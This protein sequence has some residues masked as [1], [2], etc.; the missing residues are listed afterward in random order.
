MTGR[1]HNSRLAV[2]LS[3]FF[4]KCFPPPQ[5]QCLMN[6]VQIAVMEF[7]QKYI[8][9]ICTLI[10]ETLIVLLVFLVR[11]GHHAMEWFQSQRSVS[12]HIGFPNFTTYFQTF[13]FYILSDSFTHKEIILNDECI[14]SFIFFLHT[15]CV[16]V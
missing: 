6:N 14:G 4:K 15:L 16:C 7:V 1:L 8:N 13:Y 11:D 2:G 10:T 3:I 12:V 5:T 9:K